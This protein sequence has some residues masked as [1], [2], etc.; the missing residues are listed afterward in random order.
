MGT[1]LPQED[2]DAVSRVREAETAL[3]AAI[4][5]LPPHFNVAINTVDIT[6]IGQRP[7]REIICV[8]MSI[9]V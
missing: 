3:N 9:N 8:N 4:Q 7:D 6:T 5:E 2:A 1:P